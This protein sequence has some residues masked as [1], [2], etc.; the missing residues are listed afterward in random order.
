VPWLQFTTHVIMPI[1][2]FASIGAEAVAFR[3]SVA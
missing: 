1:E 2:E 3:D